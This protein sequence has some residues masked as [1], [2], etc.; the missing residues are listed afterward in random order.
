MNTIRKTLAILL[1]SNCTVVFADSYSA[2]VSC[3]MQNRNLNVMACFKDTDLELTKDGMTK[4]YKVYD[5]QGAG[6]MYQDGLH[7]DL[8]N[9]FSIM[10]Q[11]SSK[12]LVLELFIYDSNREMV[13]QDQVGQWG[14][15]NVGN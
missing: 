5:L 14:V 7:L 13:F 12:Q 3:G 10:M 9:N 6:R 1:I 4:V 11:N 2:V 15:I 8:P